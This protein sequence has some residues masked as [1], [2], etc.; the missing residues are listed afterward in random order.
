MKKKRYIALTLILSLLCID[1]TYAACT[2][3]AKAEFEKIK[4]QYKITTTYNSE[5]KTYTMRIEEGAPDKYSYVFTIDYQYS[6]KEI[7]NTVTECT[8]LK[9]GTSFYATIIGKTNQ[10]SGFVKEELIELER[11]NQFYGDPLCE[12]IEEFVLCQEMYD[13]EI[14][15]ET[16][17]SRVEIYKESKEEKVEEEKKQQELEKKDIIGKISSYIKENLIQVIIIVVFIVLIIVS[18]IV[19]I[20]SLRKSRRLE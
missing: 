2:E 8:G 1:K 12:G 19:A 15:R 11:Y 13:K 7:S 14:D 18:S 4:D 10:C 9:N 16:F 17:E 5:N 3:Q 20:K 6:C